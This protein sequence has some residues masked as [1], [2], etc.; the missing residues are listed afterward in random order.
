MA[1]MRCRA[2]GVPTGVIEATVK[3]EVADAAGEATGVTEAE[4]AGVATVA[5]GEEVVRVGAAE[6]VASQGAHRGSFRA[7]TS[8]TLARWP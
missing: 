7:A 4:S 6:V 8:A 5:R 1:S 3:A 2:A